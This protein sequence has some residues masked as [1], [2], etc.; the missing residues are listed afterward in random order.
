[1]NISWLCPLFLFSC[2]VSLF[3]IFHVSS[4]STPLHKVVVCLSYVRKKEKEL[5]EV[6][7]V[8][9]IGIRRRCLP[10]TSRCR[11]GNE[12]PEIYPTKERQV[13]TTL[14]REIQYRNDTNKKYQ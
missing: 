13:D 7:F 1:M 10:C 3:P 11:E 9:S 6:K 4:F 12:N 2:L 14:H 5:H 8:E